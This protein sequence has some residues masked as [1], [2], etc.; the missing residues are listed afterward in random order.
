MKLL[1]HPANKLDF[2]WLSEEK[3]ED[4]D[5]REVKKNEKSFLKIEEEKRKEELI[6]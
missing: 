6:V 3:I 5:L 2:L 4:D 1:T